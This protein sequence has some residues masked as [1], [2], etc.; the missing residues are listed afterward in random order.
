LHTQASGAISCCNGFRF[1]SE[2]NSLIPIRNPAVANLASN[3]ISRRA[4]GAGVGAMA[5]IAA[6]TGRSQPAP[7]ARKLGVA[8]V[9]L[10]GYATGELAP[11]LR[12]TRSCYL[13]GIVTGSPDKA[14]RWAREFR[15]PERN[16]FTYASMAQMANA[17]DID[18]V[19]VVTPNALHARYAIA[20][21]RAGKH[22]ICEKPFTT[23][24][25]DAEAVTAACRDAKVKLSIGYRL[26]FDPYYRELMRLAREKEFGDFTLASGENSRDVKGTEGWRLSKAMGGGP[27]RDL[28]IYVIQ[29]ACM[30]AEEA[31]PLSV[32][33]QKGPTTRPGI[34][35]EVE[36]SMS[37]TM[38]FANGFICNGMASFANPRPRNYFRAE[39]PKGW[40]RIDNAYA[41][42]NL[43]GATSQRRLAYAQHPP[44]RQQTLQMD[45]FARCIIEDRASPVS[46][47]MGLRD[48]KI[49]EAIFEAARSGKSVQL[50]A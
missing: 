36:E 27:L 3:S 26:H 34:F 19:Y 1:N 25:T 33:G 11:A 28:G 8:L 4:F 20:A 2:G 13:A 43:E 10:G 40:I 22:V 35:T 49:I 44:V 45:D 9:G 39:A 29:A 37:W 7:P 17:P 42:R 32:R 14:Q 18:I 30:A 12:E 15:F 46:G 5:F 38:N 21:A 31:A 47:E 6:A 16:I 24:V 50:R 48:I 41:Y 23:T